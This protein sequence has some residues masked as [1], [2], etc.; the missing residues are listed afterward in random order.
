[1]R[2]L[3]FILIILSSTSSFGQLRKNTRSKTDSL[4]YTFE[5][6]T[7]ND[8]IIVPVTINERLRVDLA[9]DPHCKTMILFGTRYKK[10]LNGKK[11]TSAEKGSDQYFS[12]HNY[13]RLGPASEENVTIVVIPNKDAVNFF[14]GVHGV[15]GTEMLSSYQ[16]SVDRKKMLMT[17]KPASETSAYV[18]SRTVSSRH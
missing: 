5:F 10:I 14:T 18:N 12:F 6:R 13:V 17:V 2:V 9:L 16:V 4:Y 3:L 8:L 7:R 15:I 11:K 1:M